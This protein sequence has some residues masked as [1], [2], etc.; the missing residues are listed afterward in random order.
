MVSKNTAGYH[1][2]KKVRKQLIYLYRR[3]IEDSDN[4][5]DYFTK[6][7]VDFDSSHPIMHTDIVN[8]ALNSTWRMQKSFM[9]E[10]SFQKKKPRIS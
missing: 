6:N 2:N 10:K 7:A 5:D 9:K 4:S 1:V 3:Y 8:K